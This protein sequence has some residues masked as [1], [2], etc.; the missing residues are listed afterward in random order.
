MRQQEDIRWF[1]FLFFLPSLVCSVFSS[2]FTLH[3]ICFPTF[4]ICHV[5][6]LLNT[7]AVFMTGEL[8]MASWL[9]FSSFQHGVSV[10]SIVRQHVD[11]GGEICVEVAAKHQWKDRGMFAWR[12]ELKGWYQCLGHVNPVAP[13][14]MTLSS[15]SGA[16]NTMVHASETFYCIICFNKTTTRKAAGDFRFPEPLKNQKITWLRDKYQWLCGTSRVH[17]LGC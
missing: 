14:K 4:L 13:L 9:V 16:R 15:L 3:W 11:K 7:P 1:S 2:L 10:E 8:L 17:M 6:F 12:I 5:F